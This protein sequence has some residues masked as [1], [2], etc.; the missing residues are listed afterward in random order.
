MEIEELEV[1]SI[2]DDIQTETQDFEQPYKELEELFDVK[3]FE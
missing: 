1:Y 3:V 2:H